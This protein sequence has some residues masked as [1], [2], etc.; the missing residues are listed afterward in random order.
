MESLKLLRL[1]LSELIASESGDHSL[2]GWG[3]YKR[4]WFHGNF[5]GQ[6]LSVL[7]DLN[8]PLNRPLPWCQSRTKAVG[9]SLS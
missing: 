5:S 3:C 4:Q 2:S 6:L 8:F 7:S 1:Q 9:H